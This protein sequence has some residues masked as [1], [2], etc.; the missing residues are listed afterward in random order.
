M[1]RCLLEE[2]ALHGFEMSQLMFSD[3]DDVSRHAADLEQI[4]KSIAL[5]EPSF[6]PFNS[7]YCKE[8][9]ISCTRLEKTPIYR[10]LHLGRRCPLGEVFVKPFVPVT[11]SND[12]YE[13]GSDHDACNEQV[14]RVTA[15]T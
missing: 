10:R 8:N 13:F 6:L 14:C 2:Q 3:D 12:E 9:Q 7:A 4:H 15:Y 5:N 1:S 11:N